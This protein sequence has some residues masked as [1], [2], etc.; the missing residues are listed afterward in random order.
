[1]ANKL[2][3]AE[4]RYL[5][6]LVAHAA[7]IQRVD[8]SVARYIVTVTHG[9]VSLREARKRVAEQKQSRRKVRDTPL[10][11]GG[12]RRGDFVTFVGR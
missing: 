7:E 5:L 11:G 4:R 12:L 9:K 1:M 8:E 10:F 2:T 6:S 3:K